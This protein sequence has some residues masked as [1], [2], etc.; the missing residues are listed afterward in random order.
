MAPKAF[1]MG[2]LAILLLLSRPRTGREW[3]WIG[4]SIVAAIVTL[5]LPVTLTGRTIRAAGAFFTG[6]FVIVTL[7]GVRSLFSRTL[8]AM[9]AAAA[10]TVGW[11]VAFG[12]RW[13]TLKSAFVSDYWTAWHA[14]SPGLPERPPLAGEGAVNGVTTT[15][16]Q[17]AAALRD[18]SD[19][20][21]AVLAIM[22]MG[23]GYL[24]WSWYWRLASEPIGTAPK[25]FRDLRF[26][27]H[28]VWLL[29]L[30]AA[31]ALLMP[32]TGAP[33][34]VAGNLLLFMLTMYAARGLAVVQ[35][36]LRPAPIP[37]VV[38]LSVTAI[39]LLPLAVVPCVLVGTA[40]TWFD[41]RRRMA[42]PEGATR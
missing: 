37:F 17:M 13:T 23:G 38:V 10:T 8:F 15:A 40:D 20:L 3:F 31:G 34:L 35:T 30:S 19:L 21:P 32:K 14:V 36:S 29:I 18:A 4:L 1:V 11:F 24:A 42:P 25:P 9:S 39:L 16:T 2:P 22:A 41:F 6:A 7:L 12:L 28:L 5:R 27:D 26:S 33:G